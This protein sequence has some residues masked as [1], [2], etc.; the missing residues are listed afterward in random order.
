MNQSAS[1]AKL[2]ELVVE[3]KSYAAG[4]LFFDM[5]PTLELMEGGGKYTPWV[6]AACGLMGRPVGAS[7][8]PLRA[9]SAAE[10]KRPSDCARSGA[11][12]TT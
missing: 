6:K 7:R 10:R 3:K 2:Y 8:T 11:R 9:A 5:V 1:H 4:K 12:S